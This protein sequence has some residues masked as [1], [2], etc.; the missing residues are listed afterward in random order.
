MSD[1]YLCEKPSQAKDIA[2]VLGAKQRKYGYFEGGG[3][4]VTWCFGHLLEMASPED[5]DSAF[6]KWRIDDLPIIPD[7]WVWNVRKDA[8][9][10]FFIIKSLFSKVN[11]VVIATDADREGEAIAREVM[12]KGE[13]HG[14]V[15]RLWLSALDESSIKKALDNMLPGAQT[16]A[17]YHAAVARSKADWLVGMS[18]SR[19]YTLLAQSSGVAGVMSVGRVQT[20]T[21]NLVL[22]RDRLIESFKSLPY[23]DVLASFTKGNINLRGKWSPPD[24][25][26]DTN[27]RCINE[28][29]AQSVAIKCLNQEAEL[30][31]YVTKKHAELAPLPY[32]LSALQKHASR[33]FSMG[34]QEVLDIVQALYEKH[35]ATSYPRTNCAY[36]P[37]SQHSDVAEII[38]SL[39]KQGHYGE[40]AK[41][42]DATIKSKCWNDNKIS[43]HHAIIPTSVTVDTGKFSNKEALIYDLICRRYLMQFY[44]AHEFDQTR[45]EL[46]VCNFLFV[47]KTQVNRVMGWKSIEKMGNDNKASSHTKAVPLLSKGDLLSVSD[48]NV[49]HKNTKPPA[50][51]TEGTLID[52]MENIG[53]QVTD[54]DFKKLLKET[55]GI[56]EEATRAGII[57]TLLKRNFIQKKDKKHLVSSANA[58]ALIDAL[59]DPIKSPLM[60]A[61]WEQA[62]D[63]I[64]QGKRDAGK[65][66]DDQVRT[67]T[68]LVEHAKRSVPESFVKVSE[69]T[70][71]YDCPECGQP[72][73]RRKSTNG[74]GFFWGCSSYPECTATL[75]DNKGT[76]GKSRKE[77]KKTGKGCPECED[78]ELIE[79]VIKNGK[80]QGS[81]FLGCS[82]FPECQFT[83]FLR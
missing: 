64:A 28:S 75:P 33:L 17:M 77:Q 18:Y 43:A 68:L 54:P 30:I 3:N 63:E 40:L 61:I 51:F 67:V 35:K 65:F 32:K 47:T 4:L 46:I 69:S 19:L 38:R 41:S 8:K 6:K 22:E 79:R 29:S 10:Q 5:Y 37:E 15:K 81:K 34:A 56:G 82:N 25:I 57:V 21:L 49:E 48:A 76:P 53:N 12:D 36:L 62:L 83:E 27:G 7:Q 72:L 58:R 24:D 52:A 11:T 74:P 50:Y 71:K 66:V 31:S 55:S 16:L 80:K 70:I 1:L 9:K 60:T 20:P 26:C 42:S 39:G 59:P 23:F 2:N 14:D 45:I 78:G 13:W 73:F 44:P